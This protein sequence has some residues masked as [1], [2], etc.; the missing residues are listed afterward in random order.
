M[1]P[2]FKFSSVKTF[3]TSTERQDAEAIMIDNSPAEELLN[4][5]AEYGHNPIISQTTELKG[6]IWQDPTDDEL[7]DPGPSNRSEPIDTHID[8]F[9]YQYKQ[10]KLKRK[11]DKDFTSSSTQV[12]API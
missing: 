12:M 10:R 4:S 3:K 8:P 11:A 6:A 9:L 2:E 1:L 5:K 7:T